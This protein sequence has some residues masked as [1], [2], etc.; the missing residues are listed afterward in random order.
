MGLINFLSQLGY[1]TVKYK[2]ILKSSEMTLM[3]ERMLI[4]LMTMFISQSS[5]LSQSAVSCFLICV[6]G[7]GEA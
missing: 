7:E 3:Y 4:Y 6:I 2:H 1:S 5:T